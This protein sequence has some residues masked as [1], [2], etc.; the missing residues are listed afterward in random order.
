MTTDIFADGATQPKRR[1][2][3]ELKSAV[4]DE[5]DWTPSVSSARIGVGVDDGAVTLAGE[6]ES[7]P[8]K[9]IAVQAA[10]RVRGVLAVADEITVRSRFARAND[11]DIARA[12]AQALDSVVDVPDGAVQATVHNHEVTLLGSVPWQVQRQSAERA[13][14]YL[15]GVTQVHNHIQI[16]P[17]VVPGDVKTAIIDALVRSAELDSRHIHV[18]SLPGGIVELTGSAAS[19]RE[20]AEAEEAAWAAPGVTAVHNM[21]NLGD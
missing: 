12:A 10:L 9:R 3:A 6:V 16:K 7:Y 21:L 20:R 2:D 17:T 14:Q 1:T 11:S 15:K 8:E 19:W 5:L 13:V 4:V 18:S